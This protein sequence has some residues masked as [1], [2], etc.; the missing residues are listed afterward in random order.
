VQ[1]DGLRALVQPDGGWRPNFAAQLRA[2]TMQQLRGEKLAMK[3]SLDLILSCAYGDK[4]KSL[5]GVAPY[6][7]PVQ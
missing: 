4:A 6:G 2:A 3:A 1:L 5:P 7:F